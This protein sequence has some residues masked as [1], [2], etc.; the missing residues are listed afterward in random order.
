[1]I[2][3]PQTSMVPRTLPADDTSAEAIQSAQGL[4]AAQPDP[5]AAAGAQ[6]DDQLGKFS[7]L[8]G[9]PAGAQGFYASPDGGGG[10]KKADRTTKADAP[11]VSSP[12]PSTPSSPRSFDIAT[13]TQQQIDD[14]RKTGKKLDMQLANTIE[15]AQAA[16]GGVVQKYPKVKVVVTTSEGNGGHPVLVIRG[17]EYQKGAHVHTHYHGDNATVA[18]PL[19]SKAGINARIR[20]VILGED[21]QAVFVLPEE[22]NPSSETDSPRNN[23][24]HSVNGSDVRD[25]VK[26]T[27]DALAAAEVKDPPKETVVSF[28]SGG[29]M[30]L[31]NLVL[32]DKKGGT[33][34]KADRVELY[35]CVYHFG[36]EEESKKNPEFFTDQRLRDWSQTPNGKAVKQIVYYQGTDTDHVRRADVIERAFPQA[37]FKMHEMSKEPEIIDKDGRLTDKYESI[38]RVAEDVN[39]SGFEGVR[40]DRRGQQIGKAWLA[41]NFNPNHHYRT[42]GEF[43]GKRP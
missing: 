21:K 30:A 28:H 8:F 36:L 18:D 34:L 25:Q 33:L 22:A 39:G 32:R 27:A 3:I 9:A 14:L 15:N 41:H 7:A 1:M 31:D 35:D 23:L 17:P 11:K 6:G 12:P 5:G 20:A 40:L 16:Y 13:T 42:V 37:K 4:G 29:G 26:T 43:F 19:G 38:D 2:Q 10:G 24:K